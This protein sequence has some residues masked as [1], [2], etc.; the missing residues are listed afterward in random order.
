MSND[1][2]VG[3]KPTAR[4]SARKLKPWEAL[5]IGLAF[6]VALVGLVLIV[7][8]LPAKAEASSDASGGMSAQGAASSNASGSMSALDW[9]LRPYYESRLAMDI[10]MAPLTL[11]DSNTD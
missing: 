9:M 5:V 10:S 8:L 1:I 4:R 11:I 6:A 3:R 2:R 7:S